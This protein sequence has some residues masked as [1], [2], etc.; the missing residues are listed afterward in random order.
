MRIQFLF[1]IDIYDPRNQDKLDIK[2]R[3]TLVEKEP[4][5]EENLKFPWDVND[6]HFSY[7]YYTRKMSNGEVHDR[8]WLVYSKHLTEHFASVVSFL[9]LTNVRVY[10]GMMDTY[11]GG[12]SMR[13]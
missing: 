1:S 8:K 9:F 3:D 2:A 12:M 4:I 10:W 7:A 13:G 6:R 11:I 5:R